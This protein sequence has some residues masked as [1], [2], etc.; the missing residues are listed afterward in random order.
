[1]RKIIS[2]ILIICSVFAL[3]TF[4]ED[5]KGLSQAI[6]LA[7]AVIEVPQDYTKFNYSTNEQDGNTYWNLS[8]SDKDYKIGQTSITLDAKGN[9][10]NYNSYEYN[11]ENPE[12]AKVTTD[13]AKSAA[14]EFMAKALPGVA[15]KM[16]IPEKNNLRSYYDFTFDFVQ[17]ENDIPVINNRCSIT[18]DK[19]T[20]K[21]TSFN[22]FS[23]KEIKFESADKTI[24]VEEAAEKYL[25]EIGVKLS[26][27]SSY[28]YKTDKLTIYPVYV[29]KDYSSKAISAISGDVVELTKE[30]VY[31]NDSA[32]MAEKS[33]SG[34][35]DFTKEELEAI[36]N[37]SGLMSK[38]EAASKLKAAVQSLPKDSQA[39]EGYLA[40]NTIDKGKYVWSFSFKKDDKYIGNGSIDAK[41]GEV[42]SFYIYD[43]GKKDVKDITEEQ[44][45]AKAE[46]FLKK[47]APE[48]FKQTKLGEEMPIIIPLMKESKQV[49]P[50]DSYS[51]NY[52]RQVNGID[53]DRNGLFVTYDNKKGIITS[54]RNSWY[55]SAVFPSIDNVLSKEEIFAKMKDLCGY[56]KMYFEEKLV[57]NFM[58]TGIMHFDPYTGVQLNYDGKPYEK[59]TPPVYEDIK[60]HW[61]ENIVNILLEN[62]IYKNSNQF[63]PDENITQIEFFRFVLK[64]QIIDSNDDDVYEMLIQQK[65]I[66]KEEK[67][68]SALVTRQDAAKYFTRILGHDELAKLTEIFVYPFNDEIAQEYKGY[69]TICNA[70][71]I[72]KGDAEGNFNGGNNITNA[73]TAVMIY[74]MKTRK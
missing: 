57:Y 46:E 62:G 7:K 44:A 59:N 32:S 31:T 73:E 74:N 65:Y 64:N 45:K 1:M 66:S 48:K 58:N 5:D 41:T 8:W 20:G 61:S 47:M 12:L 68:P 50:Q 3:N 11:R 19:F 71:G 40:Q 17:Y 54:Y 34:R 22:G 35:G 25:Q 24:T 16:R 28:D 29:P 33:M 15:E 70:L 52:N 55:D 56:S 36:D 38:E 6:T 18:V 60:G 37:V 63:K 23:I 9:F 43:D 51:F 39:T 49:V 67:N 30:Q 13:Q 72:I 26:Y 42:L 21:V 14:Q 2:L 69:I 10:L 27:T 53:F 4:A